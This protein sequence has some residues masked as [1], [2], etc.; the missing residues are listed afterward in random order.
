M[1][2]V[3]VGAGVAHWGR[4]ERVK[5]MVAAKTEATKIRTTDSSRFFLSNLPPATG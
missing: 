2:G 5:R 4:P 1:V 3:D